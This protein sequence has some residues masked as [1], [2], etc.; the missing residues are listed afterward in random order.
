MKINNLYIKFPFNTKI[1]MINRKK[2][3]VYYCFSLIND[4]Y[5]QKKVM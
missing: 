1:E 3:N 5:T 4:I 2:K